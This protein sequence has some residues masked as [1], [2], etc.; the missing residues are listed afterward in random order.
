VGK[1]LTVRTKDHQGSVVVFGVT[2]RYGTFTWEIIAHTSKTRSDNI[3]NAI[4]DENFH[5]KESNRLN[6]RRQS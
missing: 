3:L 2:P 5:V 4:D 6:Q 1:V